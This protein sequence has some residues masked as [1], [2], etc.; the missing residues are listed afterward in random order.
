MTANSQS[1]TTHNTPLWRTS[2]R[3]AVRRPFQYILF[4]VGVAIGVA[5]MVSIDLANSSATRAFEISTDAI[6]GRATH[7]IVGG[8]TGLDQALYVKLRRELGYSLSAPVVEGFVKVPE[9]GDLPLRLVGIDPFA[10]PPFRSYLVPADS[11]N[12]GT[13]ADFL[14]VP[15]TIYVLDSLAADYGLTINDAV[16][17]DL[18]GVAKEAQ[19]I[20]LITPTDEGNRQA[21]ENIIF[22]DISTAQDVLELNGRLSHIDL[23]VGDEAA[24]AEIEALLPMG[25]RIETTAASSNSV[26]QM[27]A[28]FRLNLTALSLLALV[29]G[30][31]LIYNTVTFSVVQRR[32]M[33]GILRCLGVTGGQL[34][35]L[36]LGEAVVLSAIGSIIGVG[37]GIVLGRGLVGLITQTMNDFYFVV[38]VRGVTLDPWSLGK[39][40][41]F[42][43]LAALIAS[44]FPALEALRTTP[45]ASLHRSTI[46]SKVGR[47]LPYLIGG[48]AALS[49]IGAGL[50]WI[51]GGLVIA[52][53]GLFAILFAFALITPPLTVWLMRVTVP[54]GQRVLGA[55]GRMAPRDI[56]R[57]L[58]RTSVA[59]A[60]LMTAVAVIVGVSIMIGSFRTTVVTWLNQT[61]RADIYISPP[62]LTAN[63]VEGELQPEVVDELLGWPGVR[64][65]STARTVTVRAPEFGRDIR[66]VAVSGDIADGERPYAW[67]PEGQ[68]DVDVWSAMQSGEGIIISEPL[69]IKEELSLPPEPITLM[70]P[71]GPQSFPVL[72]VFY[73]YASD[74]GVVWIDKQLYINFWDD[75]AV[76]TIAIFMEEGVDVDET[77]AAMRTSFQGQ[78]ELIVNSNKSLRE[79]SIEIFD[80]TFAITAALRLLAT[81]VAFIGVLSAL[82][83]LQLEKTREL[84]VLRAT[85]MTVRQLWQ[86]TLVETGLMGLVAGILAI[87]TGFALAWVLIYVINV[88][89]FGWT[90]QMHLEASYFYQA[91]GVALTA[92]LLAGIYPAWRLGQMVI[93]TAVR[94]D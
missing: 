77:A 50:L 39:G 84:G 73:D 53:G 18:A 51:R 30:M 32:P 54:L 45:S 6:T 55:V 27:T 17:L 28:A 75:S 19:I 63:R 12:D 16:T 2:L 89:S 10:E 41:L 60:A 4:I 69:L 62:T 87:P 25:A 94:Q 93:A 15:N 11:G 88:R 44:F 76:S 26:Q 22:A 13:F 31:F 35:R 72:A 67:L 9:L 36:I 74:Q 20:G 21:L 83:S 33:F 29:V 82:M 3:R 71:D 58:S 47:L 91:I 79:N 86:L 70:T 5:M 34:F 65:A 81:I 64:E 38:N 42:G 23:I 85:G 46:E 37:L 80:R 90:L 1:P 66:L 68:T 52:F 43:V 48:W 57:S 78:Q 59:I 14:S 7:R 61:L 92:A 24:L 8:P 40:V 56:V 49:L